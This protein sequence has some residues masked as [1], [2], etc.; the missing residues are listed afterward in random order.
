M[1][2]PIPAQTVIDQSR[3]FF[4]SVIWVDVEASTFDAKFSMRENYGAPVL[5]T[6]DQNNGI[7]ITDNVTVILS[8]GTSVTGAQFLIH[9]TPEYTGYPEGVYVAELVAYT[10]DEVSIIKGNLPIDAKVVS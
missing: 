10:P 6:I 1:A 9:L 2:A 3:D 4:M 8:D 5:F 7:T